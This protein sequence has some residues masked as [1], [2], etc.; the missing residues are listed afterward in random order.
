VLNPLVAVVADSGIH[1]QV[2]VAGLQKLVPKGLAAGH[3]KNWN[4]L[5]HAEHEVKRMRAG[6]SCSAVFLAQ[7]CCIDSADASQVLLGCSITRKYINVLIGGLPDGCIRDKS[8]ANTQP[9][10]QTSMA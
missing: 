4:K 7:I 5:K 3:P 10:L 1:S 8:S 9:V 2:S 6:G